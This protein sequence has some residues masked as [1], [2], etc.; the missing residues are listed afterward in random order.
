MSFNS[1]KSTSAPPSA[2]WTPWRIPSTLENPRARA[3]L[4]TPARLALMTAVG[5][6]DWPTSMPRRRR[7]AYRSACQRNLAFGGGAAAALLQGGNGRPHERRQVGRRA[8]RH[9]RAIADNFPVDPVRAGVDHVVLDAAITG[10]GLAAHDVGRRQHPARVTD[11]R[12]DLALLV[13]FAD[14]FDHTRMAAH[15]V[16]AVAARNDHRVEL[17]RRDRIRLGV[18]G[19]RIAVFALIRFRAA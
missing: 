19:H 4:M 3:A 9:Q 18:D 17:R 15:V 7:P 1:D 13:R 12:D 16:R 10:G 2:P 14:E 8:R 5:P 11:G 6:P